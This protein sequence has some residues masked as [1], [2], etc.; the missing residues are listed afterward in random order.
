MKISYDKALEEIKGISQALEQGEVSVDELPV[1]V[2][3][4]KELIQYCKD[5]LRGIETD[6]ETFTND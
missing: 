4:A 2:K 1:K 6:L 3:R 5:K